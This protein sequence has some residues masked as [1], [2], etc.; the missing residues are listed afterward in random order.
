M[1]EI[2]KKEEEKDKGM[3]RRRESMRRIRMRGRRRRS[4]NTA[5]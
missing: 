5:L 2:Y 4:L 3:S 1:K